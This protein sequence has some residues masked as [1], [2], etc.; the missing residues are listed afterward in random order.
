MIN[1]LNKQLTIS[2]TSA[3]TVNTPTGNVNVPINYMQA[4]IQSDGRISVN[5]AIQNDTAQAPTLFSIDKKA[6]ISMQRA[7]LPFPGDLHQINGFVHY[8]VDS[9]SKVGMRFESVTK[10]QQVKATAGH[11]GTGRNPSATIH[12]LFT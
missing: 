8:M 2:A 9:G 4:T 3:V 7:G 10:T 1:S 12:L 6:T 11:G 5:Q